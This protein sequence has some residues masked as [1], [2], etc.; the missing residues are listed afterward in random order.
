MI[1]SPIC[2][3]RLP[4]GSSASRMR[5]LPTIARAMATR[6][7]WPPESCDGKWCTRELRPTLSSAASASL[8]RSRVRHAPIEQ[9]QL[10]VVDDREIGDQVERLEDE[11]ELA[12]PHA[13]ERAVGVRGDRLAVERTRVPAVGT[14]SSPITFSSVLLPQPDGPMIETNSPART[15]RLMSRSAT[16]SIRS[17]R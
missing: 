8:R 14:S 7:C 12:V 11:S 17:V 4:V 3:S 13:G 5:G 6:C 1:S 9:R 2:E 10:H 15:S 16:V